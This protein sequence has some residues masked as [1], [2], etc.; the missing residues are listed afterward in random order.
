MRFGIPIHWN[1]YTLRE[2]KEFA[3]MM[4]D[5]T[6]YMEAKPDDILKVKTTDLET[7]VLGVYYPQD[8]FCQHTIVLFHGGGAHMLAGYNYLADQLRTR[9]GILVVTPDL[10]GHGRSSGL[11][12]YAPS[13]EIVWTDIDILLNK[14]KQLRPANKLHLCGHSSGAGV[15][16]NWASRT[17]NLGI[18]NYTLTL[19]APFLNKR[20]SNSE[21]Y[22]KKT[23]K[24]IKFASVNI[25]A[26]AFYLLSF[27]LMASKWSAVNF[28][29][30]VQIAK[31]RGLVSSY[32][33]AMAMAVTPRDS[34]KQ[35]NG[36]SCST[37][38]LCAEEDEL[39]SNE[40]S[41]EIEVSIYNPLIH[42]STISDGHLSCLLSSADALARHLGLMKTEFNSF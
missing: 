24:R 33:P 8:H 40:L 36:L 14:I 26:F 17:S 35:L 32:S 18:D 12:G 37:F 15:L 38:V 4:E 31:K 13:S 1:S 28:D 9:F 42:F 39:F 3:D 20:L 21:K 19:L 7:L 22:T 29:Y 25:F 10:R 30:P 34:C 11:R 16:L 41:K 6:G 27:K 23:N 2:M 5:L